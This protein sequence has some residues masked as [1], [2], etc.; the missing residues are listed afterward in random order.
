MPEPVE[1]RAIEEDGFDNDGF[2]AKLEVIMLK[3]FGIDTVD[4]VVLDSAELMLD[5]E[6]LDVGFELEMLLL[7]GMTDGDRLI[8]LLLDGT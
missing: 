4:A 3:E 7:E 8:G 6:L 5:W 2:D 1:I